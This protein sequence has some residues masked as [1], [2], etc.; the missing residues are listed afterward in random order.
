MCSE[1]PSFENIDPVRVEK[2]ERWKNELSMMD[3]VVDERG[4]GIDGEVKE[5]VVAFNMHGL[6]TTGSCEGHLEE[7]EPG[8]HYPWIHI[9]TPEPKELEETEGEERERLERNGG[10]R[11]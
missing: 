1:G 3:E 10:L 6:E 9:S 7:D 5:T 4:L 8:F 11:I 2:E